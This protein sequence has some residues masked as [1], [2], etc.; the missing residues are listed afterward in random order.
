MAQPAVQHSA[1][2][3]RA[4]QH[5]T[6]QQHA[7]QDSQRPAEQRLACWRRLVVHTQNGKTY[8]SSNLTG[9]TLIAV[10]PSCKTQGLGGGSCI[11]VQGWS[12]SLPCH[13]WLHPRR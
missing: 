9:P 3:L 6:A 12:K 7:T 13:D 10:L 11:H 2:S 5:S 4:E 8:S 1:G